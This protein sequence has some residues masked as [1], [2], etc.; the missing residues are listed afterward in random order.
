MNWKKLATSLGWQYLGRVIGLGVSLFSVAFLSRYL[1]VTTFGDYTAA[2]A[3]AGLVVTFSDFGFFWSTV[4]SFLRNE[5]KLD[6]VRDILG[7]RIVVTLSL[8]ILSVLIVLFGNFNEAVKDA[9]IILTIFVFASSVNSIILALYQAEYKMA[10]PTVVDVLS[11]VV[12]LAIIVIGIKLKLSFMWFIMGASVA[13]TIHLL[14][15]WFG[16]FRNN[17]IVW[18]R[19]KGVSWGKYYHSVFLIGMMALFSTLFYRTDIIILTWMREATDVGIYGMTQKITDLVTM[20]Q[21]LF[22]AALFPLL[23]SRYKEKNETQFNNEISRAMILSAV[24][25]LP[26][27]IFGVFLA[28]DIV[29]VV[30]GNAFLTESTVM[31]AGRA[32]TTPDILKIMF[33]FATLYYLST[34][35]TMGTLAS[36]KVQQLVKVNIIAT[37][38][39]IGLNIW[40]IPHYSYVTTATTTFLTEIVILILNGVY[41]C[42]LHNFSPPFGAMG[43]VILATLPGF[44]FLLITPDLTF[45]VRLIITAIMYLVCVWFFVPQ[46]RDALGAIFHK[47]SPTTPVS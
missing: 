11:R 45:I 42:R 44:L 21:G 39:N 26:I 19:I 17:T 29:A 23:V 30:G 4:E 41:F 12:N 7:I 32:M 20:I 16:L 27:T 6:A 10:W 40:L 9:F 1:G 34:P 18:P 36:G 8:L 24:I 14:V 2:L 5:G 38:I 15:N 31:I 46:I 35:F 3:I 25:G 47:V 43:R 22:L 37:I 33:G 28:H 13:A